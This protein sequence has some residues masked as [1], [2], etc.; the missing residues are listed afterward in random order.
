MTNSVGGHML[1][2]GAANM[3]GSVPMLA[4]SGQLDLEHLA[5]AGTSGLIGAADGHLIKPTSTGGHGVPPGPGD[6]AL[7]G[8]HP[9]V[10]DARHPAL[11]GPP[12][13]EPGRILAG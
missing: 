3:V 12:P 9:T 6:L 10:T 1:Q 2:S 7:P 11:D 8:A 13:M 5:K 4:A